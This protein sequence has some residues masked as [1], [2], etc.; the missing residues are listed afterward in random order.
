MVLTLQ[1]VVWITSQAVRD[2][3]WATGVGTATQLV[4]LSLIALTLWATLGRRP[5][6]DHDSSP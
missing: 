4:G 1:A 5:P 6:T 3:R 2:A